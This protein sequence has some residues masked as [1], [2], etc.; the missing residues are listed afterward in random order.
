M[1]TLRMCCC[2]QMRL[3]TGN[4]QLILKEQCQY[5]CI[6]RR[7]CT[8]ILIFIISTLHFTLL[9]IE[10]SAVYS[11]RLASFLQRVSIVCSSE[12]CISYDRFR[13]S[14]CPFVTVRFD[15]SLVVQH[16]RFCGV[17]CTES[18]IAGLDRDAQLT[19]YFSAVAELLVSV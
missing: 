8:L 12:R 3:F 15:N 10:Q 11:R 2:R 16:L 17:Q 14:V 18:A 5:R 4:H 6:M 19:R 7:I 1:R 9:Y 13:L